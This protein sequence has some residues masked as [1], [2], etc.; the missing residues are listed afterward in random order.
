MPRLFARSLLR[1]SLERINL[2]A[3]LFTH[4]TF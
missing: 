4:L 2:V 1:G 3:V